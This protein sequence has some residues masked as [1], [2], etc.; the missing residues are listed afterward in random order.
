MNRLRGIAAESMKTILIEKAKHPQDMHTE[1]F[2][3]I[4]IDKNIHGVG[5]NDGWGAKTID[6]YTIDGNKPYSYS[7]IIYFE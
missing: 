3:N 7:Y 4:N 5:G 1:E 2:I 6:K